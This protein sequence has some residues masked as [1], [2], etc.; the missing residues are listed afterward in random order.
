[1]IFVLIIDTFK[2]F[3][4]YVG[5]LCYIIYITKMIVLDFFLFSMSKK[6]TLGVNI[7]HVFLKKKKKKKTLTI[8]T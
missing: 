8:A 2:Y 5:N 7:K 4:E 1:M 6:M 3:W